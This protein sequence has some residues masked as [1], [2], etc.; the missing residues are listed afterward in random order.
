MD[1]WTDKIAQFVLWDLETLSRFIVMPS[2]HA[3]PFTI[4]ADH[5]TLSEVFLP[6]VQ[7]LTG[8]IR[9][10]SEDTKMFECKELSLMSRK[11]STE[12]QI[13]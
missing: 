7:Q 8:W 9:T 3:K 5:L 13:Q 4:T 12:N 10:H 11:N 2:K 6:M 1:S